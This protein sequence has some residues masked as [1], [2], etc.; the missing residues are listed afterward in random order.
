MYSSC[1]VSS[2]QNTVKM[3]LLRAVTLVITTYKKMSACYQF[4][5]KY[6]LASHAV[7]LPPGIYIECVCLYVLKWH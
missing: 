3:L 2:D 6:S 1:L 4:L 7:M 5:K